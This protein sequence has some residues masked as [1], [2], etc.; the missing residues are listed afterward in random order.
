VK[1]RDLLFLLKERMTICKKYLIKTSMNN[2]GLEK[3]FTM[4]IIDRMI[5]TR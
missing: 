4:L 1:A 5:L 2:K 3:S